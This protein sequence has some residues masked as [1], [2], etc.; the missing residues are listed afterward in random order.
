MH[1]DSS[2]THLVLECTESPGKPA[3]SGDLAT[4][5]SSLG[6]LGKSVAMPAKWS[7]GDVGRDHKAKA[8]KC[9]HTGSTHSS[10]Q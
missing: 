2:Q 6:N 5:G 9:W 7:L 10:L 1:S 4:F 3:G 8:L